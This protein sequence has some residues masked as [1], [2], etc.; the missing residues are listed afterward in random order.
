MHGESER[1]KAPKSDT[2]SSPDNLTRRTDARSMQSGGA[3]SASCQSSKVQMQLIKIMEMVTSNQQ[4]VLVNGLLM[5]SFSNEAV[6]VQ[7]VHR[8]Y[9]DGLLLLYVKDFESCDVNVV[10]LD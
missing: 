1:P 3:Q 5:N 8:T 9:D 10:D 6:F 7:L 4:L 2:N